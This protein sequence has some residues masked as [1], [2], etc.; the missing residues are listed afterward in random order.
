MLGRSVNKQRYM[1]MELFREDNKQMKALIG[2]DFAAATLVRYE[3]SYKHTLQF[4]E[5][6]YN[7][8]D[9]DITKLNYDFIS[10]YEFWLKTVRKC[11]HN[12]TMK[13]LSNFKKIVNRCVR[14][15][16]LMRDP[17]LGFALPESFHQAIFFSCGGRLEV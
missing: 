2:A 16:K 1:L 10:N 12:T 17:F 4:L 15:G 9:I 6:K 13:Y 14:S 7:V 8:S 11:D 5:S 3:T